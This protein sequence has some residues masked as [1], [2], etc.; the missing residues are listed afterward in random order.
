MPRASIGCR[1]QAR[2]CR[3]VI[4]I[5]AG[6]AVGWLNWGFHDRPEAKDVSELTGL[7]TASGEVKAWGRE[8]KT[9]AARYSGKTTPPVRLGERP[10]LDWDRS[11]ISPAAGNEFLEKYYQAW[12]KDFAPNKTD[13]R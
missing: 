2:W 3:R 5:T 12:K 10:A 8:F 9:L 13:L 4:E 11:I 6:L 7:L 1:Q